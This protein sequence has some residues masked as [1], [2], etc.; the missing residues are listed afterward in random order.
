VAL[1]KRHHHFSGTSFNDGQVWVSGIIWCVRV[2]KRQKTIAD[3]HSFDDST[4]VF[5]FKYMCAVG[6]LL[7]FYFSRGFFFLVII[8]VS[9]IL[10]QRTFFMVIICELFWALSTADERQ[11]RVTE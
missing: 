4:L 3:D 9:F 11:L 5:S 10:I 8:L 2:Y 6:R 7:L 1:T